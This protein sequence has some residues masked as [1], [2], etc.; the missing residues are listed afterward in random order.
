MVLLGCSA[1]AE[2]LPPSS[3]NDGGVD[4][5]GDGGA[6]AVIDT[7]VVDGP[8]AAVADTSTASDTGPAPADTGAG[9]VGADADATDTAPPAPV[10]CMSG[11]FGP[12]SY[13]LVDFEYQVQVS[14]CTSSACSDFVAFDGSCTMSLQVADVKTSVVVDPSDCDL[15]RRWLTSDLLVTKLRDEVTCYYGKD[16]PA[17]APFES[18][19]IE[20]TDGTAAKKTWNCVDEPFASHR[21]CIQ[22]FRAKYFPGS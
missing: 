12:S 10:D 20:L 19:A 16:G 8:D 22:A 3:T 11:V 21:K 2:P 17:G 9:D 13:S 18:S 14:D 7:A 5:A 1:A 15:L 6:D 4:A